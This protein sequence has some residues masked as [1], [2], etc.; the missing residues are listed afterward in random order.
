MAEPSRRNGFEFLFTGVI[1]Q[2]ILIDFGQE[3]EGGFLRTGGLG[4]GSDLLPQSSS[5][6]IAAPPRPL[7]QSLLLAL[8]LLMAT[9]VTIA[10]WL[11]RHRRSKTTAVVMEPGIQV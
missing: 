5:Q 4:F 3:F 10:F 11:A 9:E 7:A 6:R 1:L 2:V 8:V